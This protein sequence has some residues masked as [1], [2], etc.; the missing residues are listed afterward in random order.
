MQTASCYVSYSSPQEP[1]LAA[2]DFNPSGESF[3]GKGSS[4]VGTSLSGVSNRHTLESPPQRLD[5][6]TD[7]VMGYCYFIP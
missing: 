7:L 5:L 6:L 3:Q 1:M 2:I 4:Q